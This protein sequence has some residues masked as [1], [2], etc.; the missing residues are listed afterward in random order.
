LEVS[1]ENA[2]VGAYGALIDALMGAGPV[3]GFCYTQ[4]SDVEQEQNGLLTAERVPKVDPALLRPLPQATK[5]RPNSLL[6]RSPGTTCARPFDAAQRNHG[7]LD[8]AAAVHG[9]REPFPERADAGPWRTV[10]GARPDFAVGAAA[11]RITGER[12]QAGVRRRLHQ[13]RS[14]PR[15]QGPQI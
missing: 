6:E 15:R 11:G 3:V 14:Q 13:P 4:L 1:D 8:P 2:F 7:R 5:R 9:L 12:D 10:R